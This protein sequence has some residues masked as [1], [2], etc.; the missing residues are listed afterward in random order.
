MLEQF[1]L[2]KSIRAGN[3]VAAK[4]YA[5]VAITIAAIESSAISFALLF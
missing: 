4:A 3:L 2:D 1:F 5:T